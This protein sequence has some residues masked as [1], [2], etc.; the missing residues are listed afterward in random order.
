MSYKIIEAGAGSKQH[1]CIREGLVPMTYGRSTRQNRRI[2]FITWR[3]L[4]IRWSTL[5]RLGPEFKLSD[6]QRKRTIFRGL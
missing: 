5:A 6:Y 1:L 2:R 4:S 3:S